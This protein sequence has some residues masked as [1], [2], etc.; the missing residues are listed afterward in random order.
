MI[1]F[2]GIQCLRQVKLEHVLK[3]FSLRLSKKNCIRESGFW[4]TEFFYRTPN[5][6]HERLMG[7]LHEAGFDCQA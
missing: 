4:I 1:D 7:C 3:Y 2:V 6:V 5:L